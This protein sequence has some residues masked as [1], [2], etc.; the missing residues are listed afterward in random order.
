MDMIDASRYAQKN[1]NFW[2][3]RR[4]NH[5]PCPRYPEGVYV[6]SKKRQNWR[7]HKQ[8]GARLT[9]AGCWYLQL[10]LE[11]QGRVGFVPRTASHDGVLDCQMKVLQ[12]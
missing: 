3:H 2:T 12:C 10:E 5:S 6:Y 8:S 1:S 7:N 9:L 11:K 4:W